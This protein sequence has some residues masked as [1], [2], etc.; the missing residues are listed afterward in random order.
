MAPFYP[1]IV[2]LRLENVQ[3]VS[4]LWIEFAVEFAEK[5]SGIFYLA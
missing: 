5:S 3:D 4:F 2:F 1:L